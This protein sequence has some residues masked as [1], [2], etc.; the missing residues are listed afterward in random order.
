MVAEGEVSPGQNECPSDN[1]SYVTPPSSPA[2]KR[3]A[4]S[5]APSKCSPDLSTTKKILQVKLQEGGSEQSILEARATE[6]S[7]LFICVRF[8][9]SCNYFSHK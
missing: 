9:V 4:K 8:T 5:S 1:E 6:G 3:V 2:A 7:G